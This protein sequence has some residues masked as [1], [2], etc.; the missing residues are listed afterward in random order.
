MILS[1]SEVKKIDMVSF[2]LWKN[3]ANVSS[4]MF[5]KITCLSSSL[6]IISKKFSI[7]F[8]SGESGEFW[9]NISS[10]AYKTFKTILKFCLGQLSIR[11][12]WLHKS[13]LHL[14]N[15]G[16]NLHLIPAISKPA[17]D[18][19][20]DYFMTYSRLDLSSNPLIFPSLAYLW[21]TRVIH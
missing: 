6:R 19:L 8:K 11:I 15:L 3:S 1:I 20:I 9:N 4:I 21:S 17:V 18:W 2:N 12:V 10:T 5:P 7:E 14:R 16:K 13:T